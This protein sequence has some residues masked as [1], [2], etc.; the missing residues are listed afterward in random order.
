MVRIHGTDVEGSAGSRWGTEVRPVFE[1]ERTHHRVKNFL[2][3]ITKGSDV[4]GELGG[5]DGGSDDLGCGVAPANVTGDGRGVDGVGCG[6]DKRGESVKA[7]V[8]TLLSREIDVAHGVNE[9]THCAK[10]IPRAD[11]CELGVDVSSG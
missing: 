10:G 3:T 5:S 6:G 4:K 8:A 9:I 2:P 1:I 11:S 7:G